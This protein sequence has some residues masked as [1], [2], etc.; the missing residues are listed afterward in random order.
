MSLSLFAVL[1]DTRLVYM[2]ESAIPVCESSRGRRG[3]VAT[4]AR[5]R[6]ID[7]LIYSRSDTFIRPLF[8]TADIFIFATALFLR[9]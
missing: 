2:V 7:D 9:F 8:I 3:Q 4:V 6:V 1:G 5:D